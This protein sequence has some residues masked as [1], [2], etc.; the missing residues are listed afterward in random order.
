M[1]KPLFRPELR[2][3]I[4]TTRRI[5]WSKRRTSS[6]RTRTAFGTRRRKVVS[7]SL[8]TVTT[9][10]VK[11]R[12]RRNAATLKISFDEDL[13]RPAQFFATQAAS[14]NK[15]PIYETLSFRKRNLT[16]P[17][18]RRRKV[19]PSA[20]TKEEVARPFF[21]AQCSSRQKTAPCAER[22]R[23]SNR[24]GERSRDA[25]E[26]RAPSY[27]EPLLKFS[28]LYRFF[29]SRQGGRRSAAPFPTGSPNVQSVRFSYFNAPNVRRFSPFRKSTKRNKKTANASR[30]ENRARSD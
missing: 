20:R 17:S 9:R 25:P 1:R 10:S 6:T 3:R 22:R 14:S 28:L 13:T 8:N 18:R 26:I 12:R 16:P 7:P 29:T 21:V 5:G 24:F 23:R 4:A 27:R 19:Q 2:R 11:K 15:N 30:F